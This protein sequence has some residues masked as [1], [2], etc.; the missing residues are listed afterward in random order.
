MTRI[1]L[2]EDYDDRSVVSK[3]QKLDGKVD[4]SV[5]DVTDVKQEVADKLDELG[6]EFASQK[7]ALQNDIDSSIN[8]AKAEARTTIARLGAELE[9]ALD[10]VDERIERRVVSAEENVNTAIARLDEGLAR[11]DD[12]TSRAIVA[13]VMAEQATQRL[14]DELMQLHSVFHYRGT[15][16]NANVP[17]LD[18]REGDVW[19]IGDDGYYP[20]G[21]NIV[22]DGQHWDKLSETVDLSGYVTRTTYEEQVYPVIN[23][24]PQIRSTAETAYSYGQQ[25][26]DAATS[27]GNAATRAEN[28]AKQVQSD[29]AYAVSRVPSLNNQVLDHIR[30]IEALQTKDTSLDGDISALDT[31]VSA[32][33]AGGGGGGGSGGVSIPSIIF[34]STGQGAIVDIDG[35]EFVDGAKLE[36]R[37]QASSPDNPYVNINGQGVIF[38]SNFKGNPATINDFPKNA[39]SYNS[40]PVPYL[41]TLVEYNP[42]GS[43]LAQRFRFVPYGGDGAGGA[44]LKQ[45]STTVRWKALEVVEIDYVKPSTTTTLGAYLN[46]FYNKGSSS[47]WSETHTIKVKGIFPDTYRKYDTTGYAFVDVGTVFNPDADMMGLPRYSFYINISWACPVDLYTGSDSRAVLYGFKV[48][49]SISASDCSSATGTTA[50]LTIYRTDITIAS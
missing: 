20:K 39:P 30:D 47:S 19:N 14:A 21:S 11:V 29:T 13:K 31:R 28:L 34:P 23:A 4:A 10:G 5:I 36:I 26:Y 22:C 18:L 50:K 35:F 33:E 15:V 25:A 2:T 45:Y 1:S 46:A 48:G 40:G 43:S 24:V 44:S 41:Y 3:I 42:S 12:A 17:Y 49:G 38:I 37:W 27:A 6:G 7:V 16:N 8:Q 9:G 32:L